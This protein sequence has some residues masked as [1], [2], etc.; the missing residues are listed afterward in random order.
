MLELKIEG[1]TCQHCVRAVTDAVH[2]VLPGA[3]VSVDLE[4]GT[5][6]IPAGRPSDAPPIETAI[7]EEGYIVRH[8][9]TA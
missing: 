7:G 4:T 8:A 9:T 6:R 5:V 1:M 2:T 3:E